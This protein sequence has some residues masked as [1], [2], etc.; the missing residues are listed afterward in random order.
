MDSGGGVDGRVG[1]GG[2]A[3]VCDHALGRGVAGGPDAA[4]VCEKRGGGEEGLV[5]VVVADV[6]RDMVG[7]ANGIAAFCSGAGATAFVVPSSSALNAVISRNVCRAYM[8][9][10][11]ACSTNACCKS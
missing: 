10:P 1:C 7:E 8:I 11:R 5:R 2:D 3:V 9:L 6:E 4:G